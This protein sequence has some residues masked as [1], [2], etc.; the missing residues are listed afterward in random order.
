D[1]AAERNDRTGPVPVVGNTGG[2]DEIIT[3]GK[4][5]MEVPINDFGIDPA[6][7]DQVMCSVLPGCAE[8]SADPGPAELRQR[9]S[10]NGADRV[11]NEKF[12]W[13]YILDRVFEVYDHAVE[14]HAKRKEWLEG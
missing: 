10:R 3:S 1:Y 9:I 6:L 2:M 11:Q 13:S 4:S 12:R 5:G 7:L 8:G 14:N